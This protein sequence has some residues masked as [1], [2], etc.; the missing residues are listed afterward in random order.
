MNGAVREP[1]LLGKDLALIDLGAIQ[2]A[3][4]HFGALLEQQLERVERLKSEGDW[5]DYASISPIVVGI[6]GGDGIGPTISVE[7]QRVLE[8]LLR[9]QVAGGKVQLGS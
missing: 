4:A 7:A 9:D 6:I 5:T 8:Y 1:P 2:D 3:K